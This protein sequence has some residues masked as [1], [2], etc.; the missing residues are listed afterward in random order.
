MVDEGDLRNGWKRIVHR[1]TQIWLINTDKI[2]NKFLLCD[3]CIFCQL[4]D[5]NSFFCF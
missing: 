2:E 3:F 5:D 1:L 4:A